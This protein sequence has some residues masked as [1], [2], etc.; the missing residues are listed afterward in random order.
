MA[1][2]GR[3]V[4]V[5]LPDGSSAQGVISSVG[6]VVK[7]TGT[8]SE[9]KQTVTMVIRLTG[10]KSLSSFDKTPVTVELTASSRRGV[11]TVPISAL[12]ALPGRKYGV[13][14]VEAASS[15]TIPVETGMFAN[16]RVEI[17]GPGLAAGMNV[18]VPG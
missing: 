16:G 11:L 15:R 2:K 8:G 17:A 7:S 18:G 5:S 1:K 6:A 4:T 12:V 9:Q 3:K 13:Q 14:V 10:R